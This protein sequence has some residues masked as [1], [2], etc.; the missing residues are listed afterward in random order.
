MLDLVNM[1][2]KNLV[3]SMVAGNNY[4]FMI[5]LQNETAYNCRIFCA[6]FYSNAAKH[7][8]LVVVYQ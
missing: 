6:S 4:G 3:A 8:K 2:V 5:G 7:P 1:D